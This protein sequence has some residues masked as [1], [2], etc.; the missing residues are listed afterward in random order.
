MIARTRAQSLVGSATLSFP[1]ATVV[2]SEV[3][4]EKGV[5]QLFLGLEL[6]CDV[7]GAPSNVA[8]AQVEGKRAELKVHRGL[9]RSACVHEV[10]TLQLSPV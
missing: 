4:S 3:K 7:A 1:A 10:V 8:T 6:T 2:T 5:E 9:G